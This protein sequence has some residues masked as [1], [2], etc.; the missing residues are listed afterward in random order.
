M[1]SMMSIP[2]LLLVT[3]RRM[4][5]AK[6]H[7]L[8]G[9]DNAGER[10]NARVKINEILARHRLSWNDLLELLQ[11]EPSDTSQDAATGL[12]ETTSADDVNTAGA[13]VNALALVHHLLEEYC[14]LGSPHEYM[15]TALWCLHSHVFKQF[16][17]TPRLALTSPVRG[18]GKT[19][20]LALLALLTARGRRDDSTTAAALLRLIDRE[21]G[22]LLLDEADNLNLG[23]DSI[24]RAVVNWGIAPE[25]VARFSIKASRNGLRRTRRWRSHRSAYCR[26]RL[27]TAAS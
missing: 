2:T 11:S 21:Q 17:V 3:D 20:L 1:L 22:T 10:E 18:C 4:P 26:C 9:S 8:L 19:T 5:A 14:E 7:A 12:G 25:V 13:G 27:C 24:L 6:L 15:A 23:R 16:A